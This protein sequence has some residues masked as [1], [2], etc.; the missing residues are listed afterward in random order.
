MA[1][2]CC[3]VVTPVEMVIDCIFYAALCVLTLASVGVGIGSPLF[4]VL[5]AL[6][7]GGAILIGISG[8]K[9]LQVIK[10]RMLLDALQ[11]C[12]PCP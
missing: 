4:V 7:V 12:C 6:F 5:S 1:H 3:V 8:S 11:F 10:I 2:R 9:H